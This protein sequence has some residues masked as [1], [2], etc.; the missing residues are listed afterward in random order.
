MPSK[1]AG[2][3]SRSIIWFSLTAAAVCLLG[4]LWAPHAQVLNNRQIFLRTD[5]LVW[6]GSMLLAGLAAS[7]GFPSSLVRGAES[8]LCGVRRYL[9]PLTIFISLAS[10]AVLYGI[11]QKV[12]H[13]FLNSADEHS[14]YFLAEC[15]RMGKW[16]VE[17]HPM[18]E[19]FNVVHVGNRDG[20]WFSVY[21]P[22]WPLIYAVGLQTGTQDWLNPV[23]AALSL[24]LFFLSARR[25]FGPAVAGLGILFTAL[26][27]FFLFTSAAYF[28]HTTCLL[29]ISLFLYAYLRWKDSEREDSKVIWATVCAFAAGYGLLTRYLTMA[30]LMAPFAGFHLYLIYKKKEKWG[31][32]ETVFAG[33]LGIF[34]IF[35]FAHNFV[36][37][38][39]PFKAPNKYDK[40]WERLGFRGDYTPI[41]G[42]VFVLARLFYL[43]DW[44]PSLLA[45]FYIFSIIGF[46]KFSTRQRLFQF[47]ALFVAFAYFFYYSW[48]GNQFG[49]RY[50]YEVFPLLVFSGLTW[51]KRQ[52]QTGADGVKKFFLAVLLLCVA[53]S[54][55]LTQKQA[56]YYEKVSTQRKALY[57]YA[58]KTLDKPSIVFIQ[59]F[60]G[61]ELVMSQEDAIRNA[62]SLNA[63]VLYA[64]DMGEKNAALRP[65][66]PDRAFYRGWFDR[67]RKEGRLEPL[68]S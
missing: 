50:Y 10:L 40:S 47:S 42:V 37:T 64:K 22:G 2:Q 66:F 30:A 5:S 65:Y 61:Q 62:P 1:P 26:A 13:S 55:Y 53:N 49:P 45:I 36:V 18:S 54:F 43:A 3:L 15:L 16:W 25:V 12:F 59:G 63:R 17:P 33:V 44:A 56:V 38:G 60:L 8:L 32:P 7:F 39:K 9:L 20:K 4:P 14:C 46:R 29:T 21:P 27:P 48:G 52:W 31:K 67:D 19:F 58:E 51:V 24:V 57:D 11:N 28:S 68:S 34:L 6:L 41:D 35:V 23:M